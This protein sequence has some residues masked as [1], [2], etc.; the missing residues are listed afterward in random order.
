MKQKLQA[1]AVILTICLFAV[2]VTATDQPSGATVDSTD[3][4]EYT[5]GTAGTVDVTSGHI[6]RTELDTNMSTYRWGAL[7]GNVTGTIVLGDDDDDRLFEWTAA[8]RLVYASEDGTPSWATLADATVTDMSAYME[9]AFTDNYTTTF[10]EASENIGSGIFEAL[11]SDFAYTYNNAGVDTWK[12]YSLKD[13]EDDLVWA[14][15]VSEDGTSYKNTVADYQMIV[16]EDG[17]DGDETATTYNLWVEL[18]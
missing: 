7:Y 6:Y 18:I 5:D 3:E 13:G 10:D 4:G 1:L 17:T 8:G 2:T 14:G 12:T 15:R 16:P 9:G 11:S